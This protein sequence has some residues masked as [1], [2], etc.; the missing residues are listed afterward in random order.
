M[1][2]DNYLTIILPVRNE[3]DHIVNTL[4]Q[5]HGQSLDFERYEVILV[6]GMSDD[7]TRVLAEDFSDRHAEMSLTILDNQKMLSSAARNLAVKNGRGP[8]YLLIDGHVYIDNDRLLEDYLAI[9]EEQE[10]VCLG[11]PQPLTPPNIS[12]FQRSISIA[13][14]SPLAHSPDSFIYSDKEGWVSPLSIG[15]MY[16]KSL[17]EQHGDFD[18]NFD[19]AEDLEFNYRL[20]KADVNCYCSPRLKVFYYPRKSYRELFRQLSRYG[21]GRSLL[22]FKHSRFSLSS[23]VPAIFY[24]LVILLVV[25]CFF[26]PALFPVFAFIII[27]YISVLVIEGIRL[28][29]KFRINNPIRLSLILVTIHAGIAFGMMKGIMKKALART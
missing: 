11:R 14:Q 28:S 25:I 17:F 6:D 2:T 20:E 7:K 9:A 8:W 16:H 10:A 4:T 5:L 12:E 26:T 3:A 24:I 13:R 19:A 1:S 29:V 15:V 23:L 21:Y 22:Q 18:E 27:G